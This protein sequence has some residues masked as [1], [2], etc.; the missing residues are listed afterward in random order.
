MK[1][2]FEF[3][4]YVVRKTLV[5]F[6][7]LTLV[8]PGQVPARSEG[9]LEEVIVTARK[10]EESLMETPVSITAF[11]GDDLAARQ[12]GT[13]D[14]LAEAT[15]NLV[16]M[17]NSVFSGSN[18][19]AVVFLRG[20]GQS[21][22]VPTIEPGVGVYIDGVYVS[23]SFG[24]VLEMVD[25]E[26]VQVLRGPQG[27]LFGRN[28]IGGAILINTRKPDE[29]FSGDA[30]VTFGA[31]D[32][33]DFKGRVNLPVSENVFTRAA[34]VYSTRDG[35]V[36]RPALGGDDENTGDDNTL[37]ISA[38]VRW[39]ATP[40]LEISLG[41]D[42]TRDREKPAASAIVSNV[43]LP[44]SPLTGNPAF[45]NAFVAPG[46]LPTLG[47]NAF[48][49]SNYVPPDRHTDLSDFPGQHSDLDVWGM[50]LTLSWDFNNFNI[51]SITSY[52]DLEASIRNDWDHSPLTI[53]HGDLETIDGAQ[54]SQEIQLTG[55]AF[56]ERMTWLLGYYHFEDDTDDF[57]RVSFPALTIASGALVDSR[58]DAVFGQFTFDLSEKW[59]LT[60]GG[61][62]TDESKSF[63]VDDR[64]QFIVSSFPLPP[65]PGLPVLPPPGF[66]LIPNGE[67]SLDVSEFDPYVN[68][69]F[70][71]TDDFMVYASY[72]EGFKS[73]GFEIRNQ[74]PAPAPPGFDPEFAT[75]YEVGA[76]LSA[77]DQRLRLTTAG[78]FTDYEDLQI[79]ISTGGIVP[80][81][82]TTNAGNADI[83][84]FEIEVQALPVPELSINAGVGY[85][86]AEY[87]DLDPRA[88]AN[89]TFLDTPLPFV[90]EWQT[91]LSA[92]YTLAV[93]A[94]SG[95]L[96]GRIDWS[97]RSDYATFAEESPDLVQD[98]H[99]LL[100]ASLTY[101]HNS[102]KWELAVLGTN[103]TD[104]F[105]ILGGNAHIGNSG[106][107]NSNIGRP[108]EWAVRLKY[109][110]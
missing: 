68:L 78:F 26:N 66:K 1:T 69:S 93:P 97:Y 101:V 87:T 32:R 98:G 83:Y 3:L 75:V 35:F 47:P 15:P 11:S 53:A 24:S 34:V 6:L 103:I 19:T 64:I 13:A 81:P 31:Y 37:G 18:A 4:F 80:A 28:T 25:V 17:R 65:L 84:G 73:G 76:K 79:L 60:A 94:L 46:L 41:F 42:Y 14:Q 74:N 67:T 52:R 86:D 8:W 102:E 104:E 12:I 40:E 36:E 39:L 57:A 30:E 88:I 107:T 58:S 43:I 45:H 23:Q 20:I 54:W 63:T 5:I 49:A 48:Y 82:L 50:N 92:A 55:S 91:N 59:S 21:D 16:F 95:S 9:A 51:K 44:A 105:Y 77:F 90:S 61:R 29:E 2:R 100:N 7:P 71:W 22:F 56:S 27:T 110:F 70:Q 38:G 72:S 10:R 108:G 96:T 109:R 89:N 106:Y 85:L 99:S 62:Y 33:A